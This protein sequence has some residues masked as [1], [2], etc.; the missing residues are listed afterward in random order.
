MV[1]NAWG[2]LTVL[3]TGGA[4]LAVSALAGPDPQAA[5]ACGVVW[6]LLLGGVRPVFELQGKRR[7]G[8][9]RDSDADQLSRL[10]RLPAWCWLLLFHTVTLTSL[11]VGATW[12]LRE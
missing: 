5:F 1:R 7:A 6:F 12:L 2:I 3:V 11:A 8:A 10:T 4:F 9:A